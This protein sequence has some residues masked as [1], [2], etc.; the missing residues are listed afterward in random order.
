MATQSKP[1]PQVDGFLR[2][3]TRR[4]AEMAA[5]RQIV[6]ECGLTEEIKWRQPCYTVDGQ[7]IVIIGGFKAHCGLLFFKGALLKDPG[8]ITPPGREKIHTLPSYRVH[9]PGRDQEARADPKIVCA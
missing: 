8:K 7:N 5:L 6:L 4:Q 1:N 3:A 9:Q 2:K